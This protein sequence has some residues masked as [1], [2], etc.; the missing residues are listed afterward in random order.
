MNGAFIILH[1]KIYLKKEMCQRDLN[2]HC[3]MEEWADKSW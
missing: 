3:C 2:I 1:G